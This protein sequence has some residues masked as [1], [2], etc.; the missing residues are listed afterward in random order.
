[1][2]LNLGRSGAGLSTELGLYLREGG[3]EEILSIK[4]SSED[5]FERN[6]GGKTTE[7][8]LFSFFLIFEEISKDF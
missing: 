1:M 7:R 3:G 8:S 6:Q 4:K 5:F 2:G